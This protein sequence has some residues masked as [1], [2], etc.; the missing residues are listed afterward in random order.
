MH[1]ELFYWYLRVLLTLVSYENVEEEIENSIPWLSGVYSGT[2]HDLIKVF[3]LWLGEGIFIF[4]LV[5]VSSM[6]GFFYLSMLASIGINKN[7]F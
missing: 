4:I 5:L 1:G 7:G 6:K 3:V 2:N